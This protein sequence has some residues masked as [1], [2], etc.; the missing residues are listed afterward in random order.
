[1]HGFFINNRW[2]GML[3]PAALFGVGLFRGALD[4]A[5]LERAR[6][7][8]SVQI[9]E[10]ALGNILAGAHIMGTEA[11]ELSAHLPGKTMSS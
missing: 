1:M 11:P 10:P 6:E 3:F 8:H 9:P 2:L 4:Y 7:E 5:D